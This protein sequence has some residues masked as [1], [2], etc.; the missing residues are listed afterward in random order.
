MV[1]SDQDD[2]T[3][4]AEAEARLQQTLQK[5]ADDCGVSVEEVKREAASNPVLFNAAKARASKLHVKL[6][7]LFDHDRQL[8]RASTYPRPDC[9]QPFEVDDFVAGELSKSRLAHRDGCPECAGLLLALEPSEG[10]MREFQEAARQIPALVGV[11]Q[12]ES[13]GETKPAVQGTFGAYVRR[14][15]QGWAIPDAAAV[16]SVAALLG[17]LGL[18]ALYLPVSSGTLTAAGLTSRVLWLFVAVSIF[19]IA[20]L[21]PAISL[22]PAPR[23]IQQFGGALVSCL[24]IG[25]TI[26]WSTISTGRERQHSSETALA[27][28][29]VELL[30]SKNSAASF[31]IPVDALPSELERWYQR[32]ASLSTA[33]VTLAVRN[34]ALQLHPTAESNG[35]RVVL[36]TL[37]QRPNGMVFTDNTGSEHVVESLLPLDV[38]SSADRYVGLLDTKSNT[39]TYALKLGDISDKKPPLP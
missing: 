38:R 15:S 8:L 32:S 21:G 25:A 14:A 2:S 31:A 37:G 24:L 1:M 28:G 10:Q 22:L 19:T 27:E 36:G 26:V 30:K 4:K 17:A 35:Y 7:D 11:L 20:G 5:C 6:T 29:L 23:R 33:S 16:G 13:A 34:N 18:I 12:Q 3:V 39:V 9:F